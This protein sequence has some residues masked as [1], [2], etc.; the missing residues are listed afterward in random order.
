VERRLLVVVKLTI[1]KT[2]SK[3]IRKLLNGA[4]NNRYATA[5]P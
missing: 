5:A 1:F 4:K 3:G 2:L